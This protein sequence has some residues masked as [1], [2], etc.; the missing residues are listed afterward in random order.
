MRYGFDTSAILNAWRKHYPPDVFPTYW[1]R[2]DY[3]LK[4]GVLV[5]SEEVLV[6]LEKKDDEV[7]QWA[8]QRKQIFVPIDGQIQQAVRNILPSDLPTIIRYS[9]KPVRR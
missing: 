3:L 8:M 9:A 1:D 7:H 6:E 2:I 5:A 4:K